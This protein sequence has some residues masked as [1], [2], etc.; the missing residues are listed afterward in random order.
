MFKCIAPRDREGED[1]LFVACLLYNS[2]DINASFEK[3]MNEAKKE[4]N[5]KK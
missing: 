2:P 1:G 5:G 4:E 3:E